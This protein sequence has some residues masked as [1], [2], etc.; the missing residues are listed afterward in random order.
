MLKK[1]QQIDLKF[2]ACAS[3]TLSI[4]NSLHG[5]MNLKLNVLRLQHCLEKRVARYAQL[6]SR[7]GFVHEFKSLS[8]EEVRFIIENKLSDII[9]KFK[10]DDFTDIEALTA[11]V[12]TTAGNFRLLHRLLMQIER[13]MQINGL[14]TI[15]R[16]VVDAA[17]EILIIG[18]D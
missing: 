18:T 4:A 12:R 14:R 15:T 3:M 8:L 17:R 5:I 9:S 16:E 2:M 1:P 13:L 6:Y 10:F 7:I 11:L